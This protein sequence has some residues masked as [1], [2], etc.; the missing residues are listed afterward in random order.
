M[1]CRTEEP[2]APAAANRFMV[3]ITLIS[4]IARWGTVTELVIM[5][6]CKMVSTWVAFTILLKME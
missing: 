3:P 2:A 1:T 4:C 5:N 6:V